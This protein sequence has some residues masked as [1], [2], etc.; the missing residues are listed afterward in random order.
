[1]SCWSNNEKAIHG[2]IMDIAGKRHLA[3]LKEDYNAV[4]GGPWNHF[5]CPILLVD[6]DV[7]LVRAHVINKAFPNSDRSRTVQRKDIDSFFGSRFEADFLAIDKKIGR[8]PFELCR[9]ELKTAVQANAAAERKGSRI[10]PLP[11]VRSCPG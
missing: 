8:S 5:V 11:A 4:A 7:P 1:M 2:E 6:Q 9:Q 10:L 3:R